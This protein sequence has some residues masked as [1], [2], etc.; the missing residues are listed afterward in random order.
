MSVKTIRSV[1][2]PNCI[3]R[4]RCGIE[5]LVE[6][7]RITSIKPADF[8]KQFNVK[9]RI[10]QM[11]MS[12]LEYQYHPDRGKPSLGT[13]RSRITLRLNGRRPV[14]MGRVLF[15]IHIIPVPPG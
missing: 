10:C 13:K 5:A 12:R 3:A 14:I 7:G 15:C 6:D 8:P 9:S 4:P 11:G 1:C 2:D